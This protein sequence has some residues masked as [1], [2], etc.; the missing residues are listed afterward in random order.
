[1][2]RLLFYIVLCALLLLW[3]KRFLR[4]KPGGPRTSRPAPGMPKTLVCGG[5]GIAYDPHASGWICPKCGK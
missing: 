5:C 3:A 4:L 2:P 1:V